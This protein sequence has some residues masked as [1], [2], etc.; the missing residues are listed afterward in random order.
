M[1]LVVRV[2]RRRDEAPAESLRVYED[3]SSSYLKKRN[4]NNTDI[5]PNVNEISANQNSIGH[6]ILKRM[7]T[8]EC[9][10]DIN[11]DGETIKIQANQHLH[12][13]ESTQ[14]GFGT[15]VDVDNNR[16]KVSTKRMMITRGKKTI[17]SVGEESI[18]IVDMLQQTETTT[19]NNYSFTNANQNISP[20]T[21]ILDPSTRQLSE[22][23]IIALEKNDFN[24]MSNA[25]MKGANIDYQISQSQAKGGRYLGYTAL[26]VAVIQN[27]IRMVRRLLI[28]GANPTFKALTNNNEELS[29]LDFNNINLYNNQNTMI[30]IRK[31]ILDIGL[32]LQQAIA[33]FNQHQSN[34]NNFIINDP[35]FV[36]DIFCYDKNHFQVNE[37]IPNLSTFDNNISTSMTSDEPHGHDTTYSNVTV[38]GLRILNDGNVELVY[39]AYDSDWSDLGDDEDPDSNDERFDGNDYPDEEIYNNYYDDN[40]NHNNYDDNEDENENNNQYYGENKFDYFDYEDQDDVLPDGNYQSKYNNSNRGSTYNDDNYDENDDENNNNNDYITNQ[41]TNHNKSKGINMNSTIYDDL[42][43]DENLLGGKGRVGLLDANRNHSIGKV[44]RPHILSSSNNN[45]NN[46]KHDSSSL[47]ELW[48]EED[49]EIDENEDNNNYINNIYNKN[50]DEWKNSKTPSKSRLQQMRERT[51]VLFASNPREFDQNGLPKYGFYLSD[52]DN[53]NMNIDNNYDDIT[54]NMNNIA[55]D[56]ELDFED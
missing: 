29:A 6:L 44:I 55:Y 1:S 34:H 37:N 8:V 52:D 9:N 2:K 20:K 19:S 14:E 7:K 28:K 53:N 18:V 48:D 30:S 15:D 16:R 43:F 4:N 10:D 5:P 35:N 54:N 31:T 38:D 27:N 47:R 3:T 12:L 26:I 42:D 41:N 21:K 11:L 56:S 22:G 50:V 40:N 13:H 46:N 39:N 24:L 32:L 45:N 36:I 51:G 49:N 23:I 17:T 33:K 25:I